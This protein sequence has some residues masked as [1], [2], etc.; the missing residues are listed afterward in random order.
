[1]I[2]KNF[3]TFG[4]EE[5]RAVAD[6]VRSGWI[7]R[8][9]ETEAFE[10]EFCAVHGLDAG[11][12]VAV[13]NGTAALFLALHALGARG[14]SVAIPTYACQS[15]LHAV[16]AAAATPVP[17]DCAPGGANADLDALPATGAAAA[18]VPHMFGIPQRIVEGGIPVIED[19]AHAIG[20]TIGGVAAGTQGT[21]G[22][23]SF[24]AT[25]P[26]TTAGAGGMVIARDARIVEAIRDY[27]AYYSRDDDA[28]RFNFAFTD[29]QA[30]FG[31]VQLRRLP[32]FRE[33]RETLFAIYERAGLA[34]LTS[35][36]A[37]A[38]PFRF[39]AVVLADDADR[40]IADL[41]ARG[42]P[43][44]KEI[45]ETRL[46]CGGLPNAARFARTAV[47]IPMYPT[48]EPDACREVAE[49]VARVLA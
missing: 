36:D 2:Y 4:E 45:P 26:I 6:T 44:G 38:R 11:H 29:V 18:I 15:L 22:V 47:S 46:L 31:R 23:F 43:S 40:A 39:G 9:R 3:P 8:G 10:A 49:Q 28:A 25:K 20:A 35:P 12:A 24:G 42:V 33:K 21:V 32:E 5:A 27:L 48:L 34:P 30:S 19:C 41:A 14:T 16:R 7:G 37:G 13:S 17:L 1:V